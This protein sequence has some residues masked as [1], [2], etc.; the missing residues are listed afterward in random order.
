[1]ARCFLAVTVTVTVAIIITIPVTVTITVTILVTV[2]VKAKVLAEAATVA[3]FARSASI[4][5][6]L[7]ES[8]RCCFEIVIPPSDFC[9]FLVPLL[10]PL[11]T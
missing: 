3:G 10:L 2:K 7:A 1:L 6:V 9:L 4:V 8:A 5:E 11:A